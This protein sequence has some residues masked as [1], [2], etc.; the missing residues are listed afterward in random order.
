MTTTLK[1]QPIE[2]D[3]PLSR[4]CATL[5]KAVLECARFDEYQAEFARDTKGA[6][7]L[8][9]ATQRGIKVYDH[10]NTSAS[11]ASSKLP[12]DAE[13]IAAVAEQIYRTSARLHTAYEVEIAEYTYTDGLLTHVDGVPIATLADELD[14]T[15]KECRAFYLG[16]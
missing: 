6:M 15:P 12:N 14:M 4:P 11:E 16:D 2:A 3:G 1:Y 9:K 7:R 10:T 5:A 13:A 8:Y